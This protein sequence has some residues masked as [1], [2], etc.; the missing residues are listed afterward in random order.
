MFYNLQFTNLVS[1]LLNCVAFFLVNSLVIEKL[2]KNFIA[3]QARKVPIPSGAPLEPTSMSVTSTK[4]P[5][6]KAQPTPQVSR[7]VAAP[8]TQ[9]T[10]PPPKIE[11]K[12]TP[13][14]VTQCK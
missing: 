14:Q 12:P 1:C 8:Q 11:P 5:A 7:P 13:R 4:K 2:W 3:L 6:P 10:A 9:L